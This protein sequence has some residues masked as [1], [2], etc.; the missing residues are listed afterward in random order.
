MFIPDPNFYPSRIPD[1]KT[2]T[3]ERGE[4]IN[5]CHTLFC[6]HKFHKTENYFVFELLKKKILANFQ[7]IMELFMQKI[8]IKLS[9]IW[10]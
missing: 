6:S 4:K 9:K 8:F 10:F 1:P 2:A 5:G 3:T 7:K